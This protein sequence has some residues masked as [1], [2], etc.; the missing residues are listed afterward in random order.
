M[1][2]A[3]PFSSTPRPELAESSRISHPYLPK[4]TQSNDPSCANSTTK[5]SLSKKKIQYLF[6]VGGGGDDFLKNVS[7][8]R[9][10]EQ[11]ND[12]SGQRGEGAHHRCSNCG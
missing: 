7:L 10:A 6:V 3:W 8:K 2:T 12:M 1:L 9:M 11:G 5:P 4:P